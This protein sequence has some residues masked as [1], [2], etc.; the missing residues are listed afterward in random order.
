MP[1]SDAMPTLDLTSLARKLTPE[2]FSLLL[3]VVDPR[4]G[5]L[6]ATRPP[7]PKHAVPGVWGT[8]RLEPDS[9]AAQAAYVWRWIAFALSPRPADQALPATAFDT[10]PVPG[11]D[12]G[13]RWALAAHLDEIVK[14]V[15]A[16][17]PVEARPGLTAWAH[18]RGSTSNDPAHVT[19]RRLLA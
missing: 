5:A 17:A 16:L 6:R 9:D 10:L 1:K 13:A 19:V 4:T 15:I 11:V 12:V 2:A 14:Q 3:R 18:L 8:P 7:I